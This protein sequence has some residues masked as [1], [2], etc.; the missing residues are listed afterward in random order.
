MGRSSLATLAAVIAV[1]ALCGCNAPP[2]TLDPPQV[3]QSP[4][5]VIQPEADPQ[6]G[7][8]DRV[9]A[10]PVSFRVICDVLLVDAPAGLVSNDTD[11]WGHLREDNL[12][13]RQT[14]HLRRNGFRIGIGRGADFT[15]V[16]RHLTETRDVE[17]SQGRMRFTT[18]SALELFVVPELQE[19]RAFVYSRRGILSG[20]EYRPSVNIYWVQA[21]HDVEKFD[22]VNLTLVPEIRWGQVRERVYTPTLRRAEERRDIG[23]LFEEVQLDCTLDRGEFIVIS[24]YTKAEPALVLGRVLFSERSRGLNRERALLIRPRVIRSAGPGANL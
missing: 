13:I 10:S 17:V 21:W 19:R 15:A 18:R 23:R 14:D 4:Q 20:D 9:A 12:G 11:L 6:P 16:S 5:M 7:E 2:P 8:I 1:A 22:A 3:P 24:P